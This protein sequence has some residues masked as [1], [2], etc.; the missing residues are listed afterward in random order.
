MTALEIKDLSHFY[1]KGKNVLS[2]VSLELEE[3]KYYQYLVH[4]G[5]VKL[6]C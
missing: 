2:N 1:V 5:A 3:G 6:H 4:L